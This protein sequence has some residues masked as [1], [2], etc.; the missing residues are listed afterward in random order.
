LARAVQLDSQAAELE[1]KAA[2][3]ALEAN[4]YDEQADTIEEAARD[5][6]PTVEA[7]RAES[8]RALLATQLSEALTEVSSALEA[9]AVAEEVVR[10]QRDSWIER[11]RVRQLPVSIDDI[12]AALVAASES[13]AALADGAVGLMRVLPRV[14]HLDITPESA[15]GRG[16]VTL[17]AD[18]LA[19]LVDEARQAHDLA[20]SKR[21]EYET[22][23]VN[24]GAA[25]QEVLRRI[26][27]L[28]RLVRELESKSTEAEKAAVAAGNEAVRLETEVGQVEQAVQ[29]AQPASDEAI[30]RLETVLRADGVA[31]ALSDRGTAETASPQEDGPWWGGDPVGATGVLL[32]GRRSVVRRTLRERYDQARAAL[33][34][35]WTLDPADGVGEL[36]TY[37]LTHDDL[38]YTP[39]QAARRGQQLKERAR[40]ALDAAEEGALRDFVIGRLPAAIG[41][42][43]T[44]M[45][46]WADEVNRKMRSAAA[47][48]GVGVQVRLRL[49]TDLS[50][51]ER[52]AYEL[53]CQVSD[54]DRTREQKAD[55]GEALTQLI[56]AA[57][58]DSMVERIGAAVDVRSWVTIHYEVDRGTGKIERWGSRT[59]LSGGERRLVVLAPMLAAVAAGY[60]SLG[61]QGLRI[62][63]LDEVPA[64]VDERGREGL[65]RYLAELDLDLIATSYL[66][67]GAPGAWDGIDAWDLEAGSD[68]TVVAFPMLIRG[69]LEFADGG[70]AGQANDD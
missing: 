65:A 45:H 61:A 62:A 46:D 39:P 68:G 37:V 51:A 52:T 13:A 70:V 6:P 35:T 3:L 32:K 29:A 57:D 23:V 9:Q 64:E 14:E 42:A 8:F 53:S 18:D 15:T 12:Q 38:S 26:G 36:D 54:A 16:T 19:G 44:R 30:R 40:A 69:L 10:E 25:A 27:E 21:V 24:V 47:S 48:S 34:G 55:I 50:P 4:G 58:G 41:V 67:D 22:R 11:T 63:A 20:E 59:A 17:S 31:E 43:W 5:F 28:D 1:V 60:D 33:A 66:W 56:G 7:Q 49:R 2:L